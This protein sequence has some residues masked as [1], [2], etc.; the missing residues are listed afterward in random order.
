MQE[1]IVAMLEPSQR[2]QAAAN[3]RE[4]ARQNAYR[5]AEL[6]PQAGTSRSP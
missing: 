3:M 1:R 2:E 6:A 5:I 4:Q